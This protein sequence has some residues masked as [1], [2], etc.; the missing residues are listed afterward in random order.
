VFLRHQPIIGLA[1]AAAAALSTQQ[2]AGASLPGA[3]AVWERLGG[4][5]RQLLLALPDGSQGAG[6]LLPMLQVA[7]QSAH[8]DQVC[9][10]G[11]LRAE[12]MVADGV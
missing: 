3:A 1:L 4:Y 12:G 6:M 2:Q 5:E 9:L 7:I 8:P 11:C 10:P